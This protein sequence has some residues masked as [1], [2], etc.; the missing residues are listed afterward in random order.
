MNDLNIPQRAGFKPFTRVVT[1]PPAWPWDQTRAARLEAQHTSPLSGDD[2]TV[3]VRRL[4]GWAWNEP[5]K[6]VAVYVRGADLR[7]GLKFQIEA[8]GQTLTIDMPSRATR[9]AQSRERALIMALGSAI[10]VSLL[11]MG[12]LALHRRA[13]DAD[14]LTRLEARLG[15]QAREAERLRHAH[16]DA[17][18][19]EDLNLRYRT[20]DRAM[21]DLKNVSL[22]RDANARIE[23]FYWN[24]GYWAVESRGKDTPVNDATLPLQRAPKPVRKDVWL[25]VS[26]HEDG[27]RDNGAGS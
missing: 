12:S 18:A 26:P 7:E 13:A 22:K 8:Q 21:D 10:L 23:A 24:H 9:M 4:S 14:R 25:W 20:L 2:V 16:A 19:L 15:R 5:G 1:A 11:A 6:F 3:I 27:A 17:L